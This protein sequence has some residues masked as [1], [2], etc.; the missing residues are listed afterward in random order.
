[1]GGKI[2]LTPDGII[3]RIK[4]KY[5]EGKLER[6]LNRE[7]NSTGNCLEVKPDEPVYPL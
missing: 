4:N 1:V 2:H 6:A 7:L 3:R 5:R